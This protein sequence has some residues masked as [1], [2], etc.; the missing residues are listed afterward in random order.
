[1]GRSTPLIPEQRHQTVLALLRR[2]GVLSTRE[3]T[4]RLGV[5]HMT[6]RRDIAVLEKGGQVESVQGGVR[7]VREI[8]R[9][10]PSKRQQR[11]DLEMPRKTAIAKCTASLVEDGMAVFLDAGTTCQAL[12]PEVLTRRDLTIFTNDFFTVMSLMNHPEIKTIHL[13]GTLDCESGSSMG[14]LLAAQ[15]RALNLDIFFLSTGTWSL[16]RGVTTPMQEKLEFK[17]AAIESAAHTVLMADSTKYGA[18]TRYKVAALDQIDI[19]V[20]DDGLD[21]ENCKNISEVVPE[22]LIAPT[23]S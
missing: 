20:S 5:S 15:L 19:V 1:M 9:Q 23:R 14:P 4:E 8:G 22:L 11:I 16:A 17:Q 7:L 3:L 18:V 6:I 12:I 10:P 13:G 21:S 2:E